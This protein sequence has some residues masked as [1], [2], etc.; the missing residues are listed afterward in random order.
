MSFASILL[1]PVLAKWGEGFS[2]VSNIS[3]SVLLNI[4]YRAEEGER[5]KRES[6]S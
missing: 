6:G 2:F 1:Y 3:Y 5:E 4:L